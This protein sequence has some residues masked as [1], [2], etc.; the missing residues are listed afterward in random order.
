MLEIDPS[1]ERPDCFYSLFADIAATTGLVPAFPGVAGNHILRMPELEGLPS[2]AIGLVLSGVVILL[3]N[4]MVMNNDERISL[5]IETLTMHLGPN[6][7]L[8]NANSEF[9][10]RIKTEEPSL[11]REFREAQ[12][13]T[14]HV[15]GAR[16]EDKTGTRAFHCH[17]EP[18]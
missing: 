8:L 2:I 17:S 13:W 9:E 5:K 10:R 3:E 15:D 6:D 12:G 11:R 16:A 7:S 4:E 18:V 14:T 1:L